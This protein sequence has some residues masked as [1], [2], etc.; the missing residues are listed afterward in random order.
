MRSKILI[1]L[2]LVFTIGIGFSQSVI[3]N[4]SK[5]GTSA[6]TFLEIPVGAAAVGMGDAFV[7]IAN[8]A[9]ALY[10]NV[11]GIARLKRN[12]VVVVHNAWIAGT[13]FDFAAVVLKLGTS[14]TFGLNITA[15][16]MDDMEVRTIEKPEGTGEYFSAGDIQVGLSYAMKLTDRFA[17]GFTSK[18]IQQKIWHMNANAIAV[19]FGTTFLTDLFGGMT[20]GASI[21]NF[22]TSMKLSG[23]DA[24]RFHSVDE[25]KLGA[26]ARIPHNIE[27]DSGDLPLLFQIGV[28]TD[29]IKTENFRWTIA[30]DAL[31][32][33]DEYESINIG[34]E[35][36]LGDF[37]FLRGGYHSL[38][39]DDL[40]GGLSIG[41]GLTTPKRIGGSLIKFDYAFRDMGRLKNVHLYSISVSF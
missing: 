33:S 25:S 19:D 20:I 14:G 18:Y 27:M 29:A 17:F 13:S 3:K 4:V 11:A 32:P 8:D 10:W 15:L 5:V 2:P 21:S 24:R 12:E 1:L 39:L 6:A 22:G 34:T 31:H 38:F 36:A 40:E 7:S 28:S 26:N 23:R 9:T 37:I 16:S 35:L 41:V 30:M